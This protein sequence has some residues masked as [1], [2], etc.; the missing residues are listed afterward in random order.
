MQVQYAVQHAVVWQRIAV[1]LAGTQLRRR[2]LLNRVQWYSYAVAVYILAQ[3]I[4]L[5]LIQ[6]AY[7]AESSAA[8]AVQRAV[9]H[10]S[11]RLVGGVQCHG[12]ELVGIAH[13][14]RSA[15]SCL[16]ILLCHILLTVSK[17]RLH[18]LSQQVEHRLYRHYVVAYT[19]IL[20]Q[21]DGIL[22]RMVCR[23]L[24]RHQ[25]SV[26]VLRTQRVGGYQ[27]HHGRIHAARQSQHSPLYTVLSEIVAQACHQRLVHQCHCLG[28]LVLA[29][30]HQLQIHTPR[31]VL[32]IGELAQHRPCCVQGHRAACKQQV[33][34]PARPVRKYQRGIQIL[35][36]LVHPVADTVRLT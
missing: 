14:Y 27:A 20:G 16:H 29:L 23:I 2:C 10:G 1:L 30:F 33:A 13:H 32:E 8:V 35:H 31:V 26:H 12:S 3:L 4:H 15:D 11:L 18:R 6:I 7:N 25:Q 36:Y 22:H 17:H 28:L 34:L 5:V 21:I 19:K 9:T 24:R